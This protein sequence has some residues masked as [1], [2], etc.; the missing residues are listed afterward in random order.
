M[1]DKADW[2]ATGRNPGLLRDVGDDWVRAHGLKL[3]G[4]LAGSGPELGTVIRSRLLKLGEAELTKAVLLSRPGKEELG[5]AKPEAVLA[6]VRSIPKESRDYAVAR[7]A[8]CTIADVLLLPLFEEA[9]RSPRGDYYD[10][11]LLFWPLS[12]LDHPD[13]LTLIL[14]FIASPADPAW[15][16]EGT[17]QFEVMK[18]HFARHVLKRA[19]KAVGS[20]VDFPESV[21]A[22][23]AAARQA[24]VGRHRCTLT[25]AAAILGRT[26]GI[27]TLEEAF[28]G[29]MWEQETWYPIL[30]LSTHE[31]VLGF[32]ARMIAAD[33]MFLTKALD[34]NPRLAPRIL[35]EV[36][37]L[38]DEPRLKMLSR[39]KFISDP[40]VKA[41]AGRLHAELAP[42]MSLPTQFPERKPDAPDDGLVQRKTPTLVAL[43]CAA[44]G[45]P[46][47]SVTIEQSSYVYSGPFI[48]NCKLSRD[49]SIAFL[50]ALPAKGTSEVLSSLVDPFS[51][52]YKD[53]DPCCKV[54]RNAYCSACWSKEETGTSGGSD[55]GVWYADFKATC[56]RGHGHNYSLITASYG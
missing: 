25:V 45:A 46:A 20:G 16:G 3:A 42:R 31:A 7:N 40:G 35:A 13:A 54:C 17:R 38:P 44:C 15:D 21:H 41:E 6:A 26:D 34:C 48:Q 27:E 24:T 43:A 14:R 9:L 53:V 51:V 50:A 52:I 30:S 37:K 12:E 2:L 55:I 32:V 56:P 19:V 11:H 39:L 8:A 5:E 23:L 4:L 18:I 28:P 22:A 36:L 29:Y 47:I 10:Y 33:R 49:G 1:A